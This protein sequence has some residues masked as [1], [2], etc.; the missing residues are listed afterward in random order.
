MTGFFHFTYIFK[1]HPCDS[2]Y[3]FLLMNNIV[4]MDISHFLAI[5]QLMNSGL[6]LTFGYLDNANKHSCIS[7]E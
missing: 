4:F 1:L 3:R 6:F 7:F 2:I 5:H